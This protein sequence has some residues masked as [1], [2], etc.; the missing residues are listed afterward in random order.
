MSRPKKSAK[1]SQA[2]SQG[3]IASMST[4]RS[5]ELTKYSAASE[6]DESGFSKWSHITGSGLCLVFNFGQLGAVSP[7]SQKL[8]LHVYHHTTCQVGRSST[9]DA[10]NLILSNTLEIMSGFFNCP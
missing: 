2:T 7:S 8:W 6:Y 5:F 9:S 1:I 4:S 3:H 10:L